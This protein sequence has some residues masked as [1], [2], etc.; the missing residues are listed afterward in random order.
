MRSISQIFA[1]LLLS[2]GPAAAQT[3]TAPSRFDATGTVGLISAQMP[4]ADQPYYQDWY[5][6]GRYAGSIGFY[7]TEHLKTEF[8]HAWSGEGSR[9]LL[10]YRQVNGQPYPF[11]TQQ[12]FQLQQSTLRIV[13]QFRD[14][15]WV[16]PYLSAGAVL[17]IERQR[18]QG[19]RT[20]LRG[21]I[22]LGGGAK[23]YM[24]PR[25]FFNT[26]AIV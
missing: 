21:G 22:S 18:M 2:V 4:D 9:Q 23:F 16:H 7:I 12:A 10:E 17:D 26:G 20:E 5:Q 1:A 25:S 3:A 14:N 11:A 19:T 8:E 6:Q 15:A 13:W 24:S